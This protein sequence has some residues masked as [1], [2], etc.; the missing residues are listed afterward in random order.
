MSE[1]CQEITHFDN[2]D[3]NI[4]WLNKLKKSELYNQMSHPMLNNQINNIF[5]DENE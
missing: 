4:H 1:N 5:K 3:E 2:I